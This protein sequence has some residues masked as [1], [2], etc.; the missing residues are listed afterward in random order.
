MAA[1]DTTAPVLTSLTFPS[2]VDVTTGG[3]T[4][5]VSAGATDVGLGVDSVFVSFNPDWQGAYGND[6]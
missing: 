1:A 4:I 2:S 6:G 3:K 5:S